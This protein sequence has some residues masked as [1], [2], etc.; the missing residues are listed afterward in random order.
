[1]G[2]VKVVQGEDF[3]SEPHEMIEN[4]NLNLNLATPCCSLLPDRATGWSTLT[5][6][7]WLKIN[8]NLNCVFFFTLRSPAHHWVFQF[9]FLSQ[10]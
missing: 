8:L 3:R 2:E 6:I 1:M 10:S 9:V 5:R 4:L 7:S